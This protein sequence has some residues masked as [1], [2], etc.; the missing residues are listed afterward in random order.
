MLLLQLFI[1][2]LQSIYK[3]ILAAV[4]KDLVPD[5]LLRRGIRYL[6]S[7]RVQQVLQ[8]PASQLTALIAC[9]LSYACKRLGALDTT[10]EANWHKDTCKKCLFAL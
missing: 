9:S 3:W 10:T 5:F 8:Y 7:Q 6:L 1:M 2:V 4:E